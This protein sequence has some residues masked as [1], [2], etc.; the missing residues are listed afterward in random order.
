MKRRERWRDRVGEGRG[1]KK[2]GW[3]LGGEEEEEKRKVSKMK[4]SGKRRK[5]S[6]GC[7]IKRER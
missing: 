3:R 7:N 6:G 2:E 5:R 4:K 1:E